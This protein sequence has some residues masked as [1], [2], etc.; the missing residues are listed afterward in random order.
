M[1]ERLS[2]LARWQARQSVAVRAGLCLLPEQAPAATAVAQSVLADGRRQRSAYGPLGVVA[3]RPA[4][5][6]QNS[7]ALVHAAWICALGNAV[8]VHTDNELLEVALASLQELLAAADPVLKGL[9][10]C[11]TAKADGCLIERDLAPLALH[12]VVSPSA[13]VRLLV[14]DSMHASRVT[15]V[16]LW[17]NHALHHEV[18]RRLP[19]FTAIE[20]L[21]ELQLPLGPNDLYVAACDAVADQLQ[22]LQFN[23]TYRTAL[24]S[25]DWAEIETETELSAARG[26]QFA[27]NTVDEPPLGLFEAQALYQRP[28]LAVLSPGAD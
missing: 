15:G 27:V 1:Q 28:C 2:L 10:Q 13:N 11:G 3:L 24:Y 9:V 18:C 7:D 17:V 20:S 25:A 5:L 4:A 8:Y 12:V 19:K 22:S 16:V 6:L 21:Q 26:A 23:L 14:K